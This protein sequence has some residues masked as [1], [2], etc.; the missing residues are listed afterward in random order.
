MMSCDHIMFHTGLLSA[1]QVPCHSRYGKCFR[2]LHSSCERVH[3]CV[4]QCQQCKTPPC[5]LLTSFSLTLTK[6][7][8]P[9]TVVDF[10]RL[11]W[12]ERAPTIVMI[13]NLVEG[14]KKK[15]H[16]YWPDK[17]STKF[18][19]FEVS[20][21]DQQILA[22]YTVRILIVQVWYMS[23]TVPALYATVM[24]SVHCCFNYRLKA[25]LMTYIM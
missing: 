24:Y 22:D 15:C 19:P 23:A 21:I 4:Q 18:G 16:Q 25:F 6:G 12:Q 11:V 8:L 10:W 3:V 2:F 7:P 9:G 5:F 20:L 17:D 1:R 13:T 14:T